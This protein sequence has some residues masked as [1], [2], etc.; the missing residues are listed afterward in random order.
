M[1]AFSA[2]I[3]TSYTFLMHNLFMYKFVSLFFSN[4]YISL[5]EL[6]SF[7][8]YVLALQLVRESSKVLAV[9]RH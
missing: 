4:W 3:N 2:A 8:L 9:S 1:K 7:Q 5:L 6:I